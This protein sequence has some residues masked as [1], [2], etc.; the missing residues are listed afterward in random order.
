MSRGGGIRRPLSFSSDSASALAGGA[1]LVGAT[2]DVFDPHKA[3]AG[4][5][6]VLQSLGY[7]Q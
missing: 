6:E 4:Q 5:Q 2:P 1:G 3:P 7:L